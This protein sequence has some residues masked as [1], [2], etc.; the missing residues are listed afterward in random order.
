MLHQ[1]LL[2]KN[3]LIIYWKKHYSV[4]NLS[5]PLIDIKTKKF[6]L[7]IDNFDVSPLFCVFY[8]GYFKKVV[9]FG[10][11]KNPQIRETK[12][13]FKGDDYHEFEIT[14]SD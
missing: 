8:L 7:R 4:G 13:M 2:L 10:G 14:W 6:V 3:H 1:K 5:T 11:I 9:E 12:C